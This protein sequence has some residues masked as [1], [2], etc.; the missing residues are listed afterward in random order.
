MGS[1]IGS[2]VGSCVGSA[3]MSACCAC[4]S[5]ACITSLGCTNIIY[6]TLV[7]LASVAGVSLRYGGVD[8][9][10]GFDLGISG[11]SVCIGNSTTCGGAAISY[12]I[13]NGENCSGYWAVYRIA[14]TLSGFFLLLTLGTACNCVFS[15]K[16]HRGFWFLKFFI[17]VGTLV[18]TLFASNDVFAVYAWI[19]RF[20]APLFQLYQ[21]LLF[22]DFGYSANESLIA[23]DE[24]MDNFFGCE[25]HGFKYHGLI[26]ALALSLYAGSFTCIGYMYTAWPQSNPEVNCGFNPLAITTT[27]LFGLLNTGLSVSKVAEHGSVLCSGLIFA[28]STYLCY[29]ALS[30]LP[31][32][33][34]NPLFASQEAREQG[35]SEHLGLLIFSVLVAGASCGYFAF[36]MGSKMIG[37]NAMT[38]G[39]SKAPSLTLADGTAAAANARPTGHDQVT[40][41]VK[42]DD[43][44]ASGGGG[45]ADEVGAASFLGYHLTMTVITMYMAMLLTD[46]GVA[47]DTASASGR[48]YSVG[49]ASAWLQ[50]SANWICCLIYTWTL[51]APKL[52]PDR[53]FS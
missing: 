53:D 15:T 50:V 31:L 21:L 45:A 18:G 43:S 48:T 24:R 27:L 32:A 14:F 36:R 30:A 35:S 44:D 20:V 2:L 47:A 34:C 9:N 7:A 16:L 11:P 8:L 33:A 17:L 6:V 51:V 23:K 41:G 13:C 25:N 38:G 42:G 49:Y 37:G 1:C 22:V 52:F 4:S 39:A 40:V 12:S 26:L 5:C 3:A 46:W 28:Y 19:A 10:V 29:S